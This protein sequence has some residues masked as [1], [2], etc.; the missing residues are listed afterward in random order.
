[1][2]KLIQVVVGFLISG[3]MLYVAF[4]DVNGAAIRESFARAA[5]WPVLPFLGFFA[6]HYFFRSLRWRCLLPQAERELP[7]LRMLFDSMMLGNLATFL[8]PFRLGEFVRPL[9]LTRWSE[10]SFASS[11]ISVVIERFFDLS[12]VLLSFVVIVQV[13][14]DLPGWLHFAAYSLGGLSAGLLLFLI[15]GCLFPELISRVVSLCVRPLPAA[16]G[17]WIAR[18]AGDL[19]RGAMVIKTP[20]RLLSILFLTTAVWVTAYLQFYCLLFM[21]PFN[22]SFL[23]SVALG[24]FVALAIALPS[25]PGFVGVFQA[26]CVAAFNLFAYP[27]SDAQVYSIIV[28]ALTYVLMVGIGFWLIAIHNLSLFELKRAAESR[29]T[30]SQA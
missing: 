4:K 2:K 22:P 10:Y 23:L 13:L 21:F 8:L 27:V 19:V 9:V 26:G 28:H 16:L 30:A 18:F 17:G 25:A 7:T 20:S 5:W 11:F 3:A 15:G 14:P 24:V 1:M 6:L 12:A 29:G